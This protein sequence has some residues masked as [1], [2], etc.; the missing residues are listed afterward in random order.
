VTNEKYFDT[1]RVDIGN[2]KSNE[3]L[4]AL[5]KRHINVRA[6]NENTVA[7]SLDETTTEKDLTLLFEGNGLKVL[8]S[9]FCRIC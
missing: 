2:K 3:V 7:V 4:K 8:K 5:V 1:V 9:E 6:V